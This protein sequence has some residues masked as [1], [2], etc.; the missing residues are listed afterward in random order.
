MQAAPGI[1]V[2]LIEIGRLERALERR[3]GLLE[4]VF[5]A[6]EIEASETRQRPA[7][8][9]AARF[10]AKEAAL[11]CLGGDMQLRMW[12][13][14]QRHVEHRREVASMFTPEELT[15]VFHVNDLVVGDSALFCATGI[16]DS[17]LLPGVKIIGHRAETHS[18]LMRSRSGTVV[19]ITATHNLDRKVIPLRPSFVRMM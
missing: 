6:G 5:T 14:E 11:K 17:A 8:H 3:P 2:D 18:I 10:A 12:F 4:R 7:R 9:L 19:H 16:S 1:G 15:R 13:D